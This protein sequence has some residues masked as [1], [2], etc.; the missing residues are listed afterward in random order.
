MGRERERKRDRER[1][2]ER[3]FNKYLFKRE[4]E[5]EM[6]SVFCG[7]GSPTFDELSKFLSNGRS[8]RHSPFK[9][10]RKDGDDGSKWFGA[11]KAKKS[12]VSYFISSSSVVFEHVKREV[13]FV[14]SNH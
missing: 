7:L 5:R 9:T 13:V 11:R 4:R 8:R 10:S 12:L 14:C 2:R 3:E 1:D 6:R